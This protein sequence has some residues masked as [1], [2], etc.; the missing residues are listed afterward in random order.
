MLWVDAGGGPW[1]GRSVGRPLILI[2]LHPANC[3]ERGDAPTACKV[4][5]QSRNGRQHLCP[6]ITTLHCLWEWTC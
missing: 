1:A 4:E 2:F 5:A 3:S 6:A